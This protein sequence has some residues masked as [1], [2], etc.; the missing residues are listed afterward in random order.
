MKVTQERTKELVIDLLTTVGQAD[1]ALTQAREAIL[2]PQ[3]DKG[4]ISSLKSLNK[5]R[6]ADS[7]R[8]KENRLFHED[9]DTVITRRPKDSKLSKVL[10][11]SSSQR[12]NNQGR[13]KWGKESRWIITLYIAFYN[14]T[15]YLW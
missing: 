15:V 14:L 3:L 8:F 4:F 2:H 6:G 5:R 1:I 11:S 13:T 7:S 10:A 9:L 12:Y